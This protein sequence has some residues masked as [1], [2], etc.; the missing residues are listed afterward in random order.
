MNADSV[1]AGYHHD[2]HDP[3]AFF[4]RCP[5]C[6]SR[7]TR[8]DRPG[9]KSQTCVRCNRLKGVTPVSKADAPAT[10]TERED[11]QR[12]MADGGEVTPWTTDRRYRVVCDECDFESKTYP[13]RLVT[14]AEAERHD[15]RRHDGEETA[16]VE[17][18]RVASDG[19]KIDP[20]SDRVDPERLPDTYTPAYVDVR[21]QGPVYV[22]NYETLSSGW[23]SL[24]EWSGRRSKLPPHRVR[25]IRE[26][27]TEYYDR[28]DEDEA[29]VKGKRV[30]DSDRMEQ[31][32]PDEAAGKAVVADD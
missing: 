14:E 29:Y 15:D 7:T 32:L 1:P 10:E 6:D 21:D 16:D 30:A 9:R 3:D 8:N 19:G 26:V 17:M 28:S 2:P 13:N 12:V 27:R 23:L 5:G 20:E 11:G 22:A 4:V 31:A 25:A 24:T 18:L